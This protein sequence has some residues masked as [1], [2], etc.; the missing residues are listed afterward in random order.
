M[1][2]RVR[3]LSFL[4]GDPENGN[5][6][7]HVSIVRN[8]RIEFK[9]QSRTAGQKTGGYTLWQPS[10]RKR[11]LS[12]RVVRTILAEVNPRAVHLGDQPVAIGDQFGQ[13]GKCFVRMAFP[14]DEE[15]AARTS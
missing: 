9:G 11:L 4:H 3:D 1:A 15:K 13:G 5:L 2:K 14:I 10:G 8:N 12:R 7:V 6:G